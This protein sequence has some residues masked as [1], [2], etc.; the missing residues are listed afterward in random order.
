METLK[1]YLRDHDFFK[2]MYPECRETI[3]GCGRTAR[4]A[5]G[6]IIVKEGE[7]ANYFYMIRRGKVGIEIPYPGHGAV[8]IQTL[9]AGEVFGWEWLIPPHQWYLNAKAMEDTIVYLFDGACLRNKCELNKELGFVMMRQFAQIIT[10][11][12]HSARRQILDLVTL[13]QGSSLYENVN[14]VPE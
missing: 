7:E 14:A 2:E 6:E 3:A 9:A 5:K 1:T 4:Y 8:T 12:L 13:K 11:R 10:K